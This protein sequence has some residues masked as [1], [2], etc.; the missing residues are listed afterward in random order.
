MTKLRKL[1]DE[2]GLKQCVVARWIKVD[3]SLLSRFA[4]GER[5]I[6][7]EKVAELAEML[8]VEESEIVGEVEL[9]DVI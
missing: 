4:S 1:L 8:C 2:S 7:P 5:I 3:P 6:P 9:I